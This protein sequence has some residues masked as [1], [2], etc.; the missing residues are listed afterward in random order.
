MRIEVFAEADLHGRY[1]A[2]RTVCTV[3]GIAPKT[4]LQRCGEESKRVPD[5]VQTSMGIKEFDREVRLYAPTL[6]I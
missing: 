4:W 5:L 2:I 1:G 6:V 3:C